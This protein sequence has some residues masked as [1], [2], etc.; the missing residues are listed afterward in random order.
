VHRL[1][2]LVLSPP[3]SAAALARLAPCLGLALSLAACSLFSAP[4]RYRGQNVTPEEL[5]QLVPG[6]TTEADVTTLLGSPSSRGLFDPNRWAYMGQVTQS[7][8]GRYPGVVRDDVVVLTFNGEGVLQSVQHL[9]KKSAVQVG[10]AAGSTPSPG[11]TASFF[12]QLIGNVG[13]YTPGGLPGTT[14]GGGQGGLGG[15]QP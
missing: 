14:T 9:N 12:Q 6:T 1:A 11:G 3:G 8:I 10:M 13:R 2:R 5:K 15:G 4:L 7:R